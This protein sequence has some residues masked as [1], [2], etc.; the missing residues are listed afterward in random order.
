[1]RNFRISAEGTW[2]IEME[3]SR[4]SFGIVTAF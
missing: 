2:D 3:H 4:W 1:M